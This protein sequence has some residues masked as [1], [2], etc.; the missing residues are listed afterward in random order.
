MRIGETEVKDIVEENSP[1]CRE[2]MHEDLKCTSLVEE[3]HTE[4]R[5]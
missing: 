5:V 1:G 2:A 4:A 3:Q